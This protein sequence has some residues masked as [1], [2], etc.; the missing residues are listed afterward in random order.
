MNLSTEQRNIVESSEDKIVVMSA[1][2][3]GKTHT[4]IERIR[5]ILKQGCDPTKMV[6]ITFTNN[7]AEEIR[8][9]LGEDYQEGMFVGTVHSY[10]NSLLTKAGVQTKSFIR[11]EEFDE[12]FN[13]II[14]NPSVIEEVDFLA[15]DE[16][17]DSS[18]AQ[19]DFIFNMIKPKG[20]L[21]VGDVR[22]SIY[23]FNNANPKLILS[24]SQ[25]DDVRTYSMIQ[26][27]RNGTEI[28]NYSNWILRKMKEIPVEEVLGVRD[29]SGVVE[30]IRLSQIAGILTKPYGDWAILCRYNKTIARILNVLSSQ[31]IP[32]ITFRQAQQGRSELQDKINSN[33]VK[34]LTIHSSKGLEF[35]NVIVAEQ[36]WRSEENLRLMYVAAT[37]AKNELY[38]VKGK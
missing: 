33:T 4:L 14:D 30:T 31:G 6:C 17:Q 23:G 18:I 5:W 37:R 15:L 24:L 12:L 25:D 34:V 21:V 11:E 36:I 8:V 29:S 27:H 13:L 38:W 1:A 10:A 28:I 32:A 20:F 7:A 2:A 35:N 16:A 19:F 3:S 26:N 22:Q 9:R